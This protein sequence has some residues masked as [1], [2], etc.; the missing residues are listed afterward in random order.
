MAS[1]TSTPGWWV[2]AETGLP[3]RGLTQQPSGTTRVIASKKPSFFG[4]VGST[5]LASCA[6]TY[7]RVLPK[8]DH[9]CSSS[10]VS[11]PVKSTVRWSPSTVRRTCT[12]MSVFPAGSLSTQASASYTPSGQEA[13]SSRTR[14]AVSATLRSTHA[15]I[16]S[17]P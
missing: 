11:D 16:V 17:A 9:A 10:R 12:R 3:G 8:V 14:R 1:P 5:R 2:P 7:P 4:I 6:I 15:R 13:I